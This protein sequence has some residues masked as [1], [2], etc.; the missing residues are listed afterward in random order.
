VSR[1][2]YRE[3]RFGCRACDTEARVWQWETDWPPDCPQCLFPMTPVLPPADRGPTVIGDACDVV[4]EHG[5]CW[6]GGA[7]RRYT[8][9]SEM[10]KEAQVR[11]LINRVEHVPLPGTDKSP[12]TTRWI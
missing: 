2:T 10:K 11:G 8:S 12:F 1:H 9:K 5:I 7:P 4:I 6:P 3:R